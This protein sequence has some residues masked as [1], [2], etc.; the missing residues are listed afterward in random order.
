[1][2]A[3]NEKN[4]TDMPEWTI[5][6]NEHINL[7][8]SGVTITSRI[9]QKCSTTHNWRE[10]DVIVTRHD[11]VTECPGSR[12]TR[13]VIILLKLMMWLKLQDV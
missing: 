4:F 7:N 10:A 5:K 11:S 8:Y 12:Q 2:T 6:M 13:Q 1:M 3:L 9:K